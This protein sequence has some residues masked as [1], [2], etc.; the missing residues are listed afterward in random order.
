MASFRQWRPPQLEPAPAVQPKQCLPTLMFL[1]IKLSKLTSAKPYQ[2]ANIYAPKIRNLN[3]VAYKYFEGVDLFAIKGV[4]HAKVL[5]IMSEIGLK[6]LVKF[7]S[8]KQIASWVRLALN[9]KISGV[10]ILSH[11]ILKGSNRLK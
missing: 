6:G 4:S 9:N 2:E 7:S 10:E 11:R 8:A 3:L 1:S 5:S